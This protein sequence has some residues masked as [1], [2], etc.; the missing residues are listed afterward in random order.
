MRHAN[1]HQ[2]VACC[3]IRK[4][5]I[6]RA[7]WDREQHLSHH[8]AAAQG[9]FEHPGEEIIGRDLALVGEHGRT[10]S[11][12]HRRVVGRGVVI[13]QRTAQGPPVAHLRIADR[14]G[15]MRQNRDG[16]PQFHVARNLGMGGRR[17]DMRSLA[18]ELDSSQLVD[19]GQVDQLRGFVQTHLERRQQCHSTGQQHGVAASNKTLGRVA[20]RTGAVIV[21]FA[22]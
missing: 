21:K 15:S 12:R 2:R 20:H 16:R 9:R 19:V 1:A 10:Q 6:P 22:H 3:R 4:L 5:R 17:A 13:G 18:A 14:L 7:L 11:Q 8:L